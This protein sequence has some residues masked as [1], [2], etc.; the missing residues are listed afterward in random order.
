[1][2]CYWN[3]SVLSGKLSD[4]WAVKTYLVFSISSEVTEHQRPDIIS[5]DLRRCSLRSSGAQF[6]YKYV[7]NM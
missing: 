5:S 4:Y 7:K 6:F 1:M 2:L 3:C